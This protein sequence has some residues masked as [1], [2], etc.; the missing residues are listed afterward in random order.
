MA[1]VDEGLGFGVWVFGFGVRVWAL[2]S[3]VWG[4]V[5]GVRF[6]SGGGIL[7]QNY[8]SQSLA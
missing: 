4:K 5:L 3:R 6:D 7:D 2:G 8:D 1:V